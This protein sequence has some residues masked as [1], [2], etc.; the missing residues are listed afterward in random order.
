MKTSKEIHLGN[1]KSIQFWLFLALV[2]IFVL[3]FQVVRAQSTILGNTGFERICPRFDAQGQPFGI[4]PCVQRIY[5]FSLGFG[6]VIALF[7]IV[8]AGYRYM[9]AQGSAEQVQSAK[10]SFSSAFIG[11]IIIFVAFILLYVIN[12][13]LVRFKRLELPNIP[14]TKK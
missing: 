9:T 7:L 6:S 13:D 4:A 3:N 2:S 5:L 10:D 11:L 1:K 12:P 8:L 14:S